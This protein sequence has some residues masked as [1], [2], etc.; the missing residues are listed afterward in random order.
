MRRKTADEERERDFGLN[1][2]AHTV[3]VGC[4][5]RRCE[6]QHKV[7]LNKFNFYFIFYVPQTKPYNN[8]ETR[9]CFVL[10]CGF[11]QSGLLVCCT[12]SLIVITNKHVINQQT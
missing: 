3:S 9:P 2:R 7:I 4:E 11:G 1:K 8:D 12:M 5:W 10:L 6:R